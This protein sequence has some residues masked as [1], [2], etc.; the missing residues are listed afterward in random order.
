[1]KMQESVELHA[2]LRERAGKGAARA[3]RRAGKV[4]GV[5][6][7]GKEAP[8]II[9]LDPREIQKGMDSGA[10]FATML[11]VGD[12]SERV[13]PR[14]LQLHP[15]KGLA[16]HVDLLR[17]TSA[18][19][20]TVE[21]ACTFLNE[22]E[23]P[24][25]KRGGVLNVV[26]FAIEVICGV[27]DIPQGFDIDLT[28]L[29]IGDSVHASTLTLPSGV[30]LTITDRDFTIATIAAPTVVAEEEAAEAAEGEEGEEGVEGEEGAEGAE[31]A[32]GESAEE[33]EKKDDE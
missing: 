4:P 24:G 20:V 33:G 9:N 28:G 12:D 22:E 5:V 23:S 26:R 32:E 8:K 6:Y 18:T 11:K 14:D 1:M 16:Q 3:A 13:I 10:F 19:R 15:V 17:V 21:V 7:G 27:D 2:D 31:G 29:E 30:E 25:L